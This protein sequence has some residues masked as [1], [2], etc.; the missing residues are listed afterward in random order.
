MVSA[1]VFVQIMAFYGDLSGW[2]QASYD[3]YLNRE[4][5]LNVKDM[6]EA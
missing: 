3:S 5:K 2:L 1:P 4:P 6:I